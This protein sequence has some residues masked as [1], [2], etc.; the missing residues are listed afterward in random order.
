MGAWIEIN[1][2]SIPQ[3]ALIPV[4]P[5]MGAWIEITYL[6]QIFCLNKVAPFMG[7]WIEIVSTGKLSS[8]PTTVAPFMGAWI[9]ING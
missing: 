8:S 2:A 1:P 7:A 6:M 4:A 9:E 5:F 3:P